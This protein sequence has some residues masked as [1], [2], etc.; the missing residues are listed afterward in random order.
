M[1]QQGSGQGWGPAPPRATGAGPI[2]QPQ[3]GNRQQGWRAATTKEESDRDVKRG[4]GEVLGPS[5]IRTIV[6]LVGTALG[7]P[8][9]PW[10]MAAG[11]GLAGL[12]AEYLAQ[13]AEG[14]TDLGKVEMLLQAAINA[15]PI[16]GGSALS[17]G[18]RSGVASAAGNL[19][20]EWGASD[21]LDD[22]LSDLP[23][24]AERTAAA[25][26]FG[27]VLGAGVQKGMSAAGMP[28]QLGGERGFWDTILGRNAPAAADAPNGIILS[29][30]RETNRA[31]KVGGVTNRPRPA[32]TESGWQYETPAQAAM[33]E[34]E[35]RRIATGTTPGVPVGTPPPAD[36]SDVTPMPAADPS[37]VTFTPGNQGTP[38]PEPTTGMAG[39]A[40]SQGNLP[41]TVG[42]Q[43]LGPGVEPAPLANELLP[44]TPLTADSQGGLNLRD[45]LGD[46]ADRRPPTDPPPPPAGVGPLDPPAPPLGPTNQGPAFPPDRLGTPGPVPRQVQGPPALPTVPEDAAPGL[47]V[48]GRPSL[49]EQGTPA[50]EPTAGM[51]GASRSRGDVP[52]E[53]T[54]LEA[55][56]PVLPP[57]GP[58]FQGFNAPEPT[59]GMAGSS[60]SVGSTPT[61]QQMGPA[62]PFEVGGNDP[63]ETLLAQLRE[64][65]GAA[66]TGGVYQGL[67]APPSAGLGGVRGPDTGPAGRD[68]LAFLSG[69]DD[70]PKLDVLD[71]TTA[72]LNGSGESGS[73]LEAIRRLEG[74]KGRGE[75]FGVYDATG[76]YRTLQGYGPEAVDYKVQPGEAYGVQGPDGFQVR[77]NAGGRVPP[78]GTPPPTAAAAPIEA[79]AGE[80]DLG[81]LGALDEILNPPP[82]PAAA[83]A[84]PRKFFV[85]AE[86]HA[87]HEK[88]KAMGAN[89]EPDVVSYSRRL[90]ETEN[91]RK[92]MWNERVAQRAAKARV[93]DRLA[94]P[95]P[96][97]NPGV[98]GPEAFEFPGPMADDAGQIDNEL[99]TTLGL[100]SGGAFVGGTT[101]AVAGD[102]EDQ[103]ANF[104]GGAAVGG[105]TPL[106]WRNPE[107]LQRIRYGSMLSGT[108]AQ[109]SNIIGG[110][111]S[112]HVRAAEEAL[113]GNL[114]Q[115]GR[116]V[117][118]M[119]SP[120]T[121]RGMKHA[122]DTNEGQWAEG[123]TR[124]GRTE[125]ALGMPSRAL[126]AVDE[127][128]T[129]ALRRAGLDQDEATETLFTNTPLSATGQ[130]LSE[131]GPLLSTVAP[132]VKTASNMVERGL[133]HTPG[134]AMLPWVQNMRNPSAGQSAA[135][136]GLGALAMLASGA[137]L[138]PE[139]G[140]MGKLSD[141]ALGPLALPANAAAQIRDRWN[142]GE[143]PTRAAA[144]GLT[145]TIRNMAPIASEGYDYDP[146]RYLASFVPG[147]LGMFGDSPS[148][149]RTNGTLFDPAIAK[150]PGLQDTLPR[151]PQSRRR[152]SPAATRSR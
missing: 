37:R 127:G 55:L 149:F 8:G 95:K 150:I 99:L 104:M 24:V 116:I 145:D 16:K 30:E 109:L 74:M 138:L 96:T 143:D 76:Q 11:G 14:R 77:D 62:E 105:A 131:R 4:T 152:S 108:G 140:T 18:V 128:Y 124:W 115:A 144:G 103:L 129:Q 73:S 91:E 151:K 29:A 7:A 92:L 141:A 121:F 110:F 12:L 106:L 26:A 107:L 32:R 45:A 54:G 148:E 33:R 50:V 39:S 69:L 88:L 132:F 120:D 146:G 67:P 86:H 35:A 9:G 44:P 78:A 25:T 10:G 36:L 41:P 85:P 22:L 84:A 100:H 79:P 83:S 31:G 71:P 19:G 53:P 2:G 147:A 48:G 102:D 47:Q 117:R 34:A 142:K 97:D 64:A 21:G 81:D 89:V 87:S 75:E 139:E 52:P 66:R 28:D 101:A 5:G 20:A 40:R 134:V 119:W 59:A 38:A 23:G 65:E 15:A 94:T 125:G 17:T 43:V 51:A 63:I 130:Y 135:R 114:P 112:A 13:K 136:Q 111:G 98:S 49:L 118:E 57:L 122:W 90:Q 137:G 93:G 27:G 56:D 113:Q 70:A 42:S 46:A 126:H 133:E 68:P 61:P 82:A 72:T 3:P 58:E 123:G 80:A 60:R 6:P 1:P